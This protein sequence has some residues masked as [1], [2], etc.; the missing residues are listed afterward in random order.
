MNTVSVLQ[1]PTWARLLAFFPGTTRVDSNSFL[2]P[3]SSQHCV[4]G[5]S[6]LSYTTMIWVV[7][8]LR[9]LLFEE[10]SR[11][12]VGKIDSVLRDMS[13][14][15]LEA[16]DLPGDVHINVEYLSMS[17]RNAVMAFRFCSGSRVHAVVTLTQRLF[18]L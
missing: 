8:A 16:I 7:E 18:C 3:L 5:E 11:Q 14:T 13:A 9:D 12:R 10:L 1:F 6:R 4:P 15:F 2:I 17:E